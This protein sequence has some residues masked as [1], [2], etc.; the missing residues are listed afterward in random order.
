MIRKQMPAKVNKILLK[1]FY[2]KIFYLKTILIV[3]CTKSI[4]IRDEH[5]PGGPRAGP[6]CQKSD[7]IA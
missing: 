4:L 5:G 6:D 1:I 2:S 7:F 3:N